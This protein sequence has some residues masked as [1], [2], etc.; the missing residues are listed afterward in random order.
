MG[1]RKRTIAPTRTMEE[2]EEELGIAGIANRESA[3]SGLSTAARGKKDERRESN[4]SK[5]TAE[6][7]RENNC[8]TRLRG[9][10]GLE[11]KKTFRFRDK[12]LKIN[13]F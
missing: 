10:P 13:G 8:D 4:S 5:E 9:N 12:R 11:P 7:S 6:A 3:A 1:K 2:G